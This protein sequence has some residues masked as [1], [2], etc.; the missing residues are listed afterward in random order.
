MKI[1]FDEKILILIFII[2]SILL[3]FMIVYLSETYNIQCLSQGFYSSN[4]IYFKSEKSNNMNLDDLSK[5]IKNCI[6]FKELDLNY[7][8]RGVYFTGKIIKPEMKDGRFFDE[9]DFVSRQNLAV[10]GSKFNENIVEK[11]DNKYMIFNDIEYKI[12]GIMGYNQESKIDRA[13]FLTL[14]ETLLN[15]PGTFAIDGKNSFDVQNSYNSITENLEESLQIDREINSINRF[16]ELEKYN[17]TMFCMLIISL[18]LTTISISLYWIKKRNRKIAILRLVG[19]SDIRIILNIVSRFLKL[20][21]I[22]ILFG[23]AIGI[24]GVILLGYKLD[25][26]ML[27]IPYITTILCCLSVIIIPIRK[28]L[29]IDVDSQLRCKL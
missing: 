5:I 15:S 21:H 13:C 26:Y 24:I 7:D 20:I 29:M 2:I 3:I 17:L 1:R 28:A 8:I 14:N 25:I 9:T 11:D 22:A 10:V 12:I 19:Y 4:T 27:I 16:F 18:L 6:L 23:F